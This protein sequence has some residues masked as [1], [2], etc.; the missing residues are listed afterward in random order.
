MRKIQA[1]KYS[2]TIREIAKEIIPYLV[3]HFKTEDYSQLY[4]WDEHNKFVYLSTVM[5]SSVLKS[6][7]DRLTEK[8]IP[9][10]YDQLRSLK[11]SLTL[12]GNQSSYSIRRHLI[13]IRIPRVRS[14]QDWDTYLETL[15]PST[16][17][18]EFVHAVDF[19]RG[20][21]KVYDKKILHDKSKYY[22]HPLEINALVQEA[23]A[24]YEKELS[25]KI[26][27]VEATSKDLEWDFLYLLG[28][29]TKS[30]VQ[31]FLF[32]Y[33]DN[34]LTQ[35]SLDNKEIVN[36]LYHRLYK[37][38]E[39]VKEVYRKEMQRKY[40]IGFSN[41]A[42]WSY[43][44]RERN[45]FNHKGNN[46][47]N[48]F[49]KQMIELGNANPELRPHISAVLNATTKTANASLDTA[50]VKA[51]QE[52]SHQ[53]QLLLDEKARQVVSSLERD[54]ARCNA[55]ITKV[56]TLKMPETSVRVYLDVSVGK[57]FKYFSQDD[58]DQ[59]V[60]ILGTGWREHSRKGM[61][62][63]RFEKDFDY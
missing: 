27:I 3:T 13:T 63:I 15:F 23:M 17:L 29:T 30:E 48:K 61:T 39:M 1:R 8:G 52:A 2:L 7:I 54:L 41:Q 51:F 46:I 47:M 24:S 11:V 21:P 6:Q 36:K 9:V 56:V 26:K 57:N 28:A 32:K 58:L 20:N 12:E 4:L 42:F 35:N 22:T 50:M 37:E 14:Q 19:M 38:I 34:N 25:P 5:S 59:V 43:A 60:E 18:H 55:I 31:D 40:D 53:F 62:S 45:F 33:L 44:D 16:F 10:T 49:S